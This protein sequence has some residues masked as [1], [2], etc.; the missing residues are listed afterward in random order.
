MLKHTQDFSAELDNFMVRHQIKPGITGL[1]QSKGYRGETKDFEKKK[2][3]VK[4]DL[5]Y[6]RNWS[7][8]LDL[9]IILATITTLFT[10]FKEED[11]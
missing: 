1:A 3:R 6:V 8:L 4:L 7:L 11:L 2:N 5:F 10:G 9:K